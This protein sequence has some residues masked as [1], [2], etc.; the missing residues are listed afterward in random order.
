VPCQSW[1]SDEAGLGNILSDR[2]S[3]IWKHKLA[4]TLRGM[5]EEKALSC[6]F[7]SKREKENENV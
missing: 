1:L 7:R 5:N 6:P 4:R 3:S 2:F